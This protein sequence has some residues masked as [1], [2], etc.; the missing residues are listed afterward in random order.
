MVTN[1]NKLT[2][3]QKLAY[4]TTLSHIM[5]IDRDIADEEIDFLKKPQQLFSLLHLN[6]L[7]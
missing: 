2:K 1:K 4:L 3:N 5:H 7:A 6:S